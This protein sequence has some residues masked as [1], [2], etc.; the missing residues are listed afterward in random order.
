VEMQVEEVDAIGVVRC[1]EGLI[2]SQRQS[3][4]Q[5]V[6][7]S[8][9]DPDLD[10]GALPEKERTGQDSN[11]FESLEVLV[12]DRLRVH[13]QQQVTHEDVVLERNGFG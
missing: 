13:Q 7:C 6:K 11:T 4:E 10:A 9:L 8:R 12:A 5:S 2:S 3:A 1:S